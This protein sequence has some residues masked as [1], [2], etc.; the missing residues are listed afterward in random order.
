MAI[1]KHG[2]D[3]TNGS[4]AFKE[5]VALPSEIERPYVGSKPGVL[6]NANVS[7]SS[8]GSRKEIVDCIFAG[9]EALNIRGHSEFE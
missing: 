4:I 5:D 6:L 9:N 2:A 1:V 3:E 7:E 8:G